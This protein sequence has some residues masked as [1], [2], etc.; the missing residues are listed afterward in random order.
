[1]DANK[2]VTSQM[3]WNGEAFEVECPLCFEKCYIFSEN[4][5]VCESNSE[6]KFSLV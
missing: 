5:I 3:Y 2:L 6:H 4:D 1:M